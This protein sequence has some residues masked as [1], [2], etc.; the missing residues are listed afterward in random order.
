[1]GE[2]HMYQ[3]TKVPKEEHSPNLAGTAGKGDGVRIPMQNRYME[4]LAGTAGGKD[5]I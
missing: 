3:G 5:K 1:M 2:I 4:K